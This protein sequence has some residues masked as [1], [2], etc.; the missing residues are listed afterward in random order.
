MA[1]PSQEI[2]V[3]GSGKI[4]RGFIADL[5]K[6]SGFKL[7]FCDTS[8]PLIEAMR[9]AGKYT[10]VNIGVS[11][12]E[13]VEISN[14]E[15]L[16]IQNDQPAYLDKMIQ[17]DFIALAVYSG[18]FPAIAKDFCEVIR[19]RMILRPDNDFNIILCVNVLGTPQFFADYFASHLNEQEMDFVNSHVGLVQALVLRAG[20]EATEEL[21]AKDP[22]V[23]V[24]NGFGSLYL[25]RDAF[26]GEC[27]IKSVELVD[28]IADRFTRKIYS[29]NLGH[30]ALAYMG[31]LC[32]MTYINE[33]LDNQ[34]IFHTMIGA[35]NEAEIGMQKEFGFSDEDTKKWRQEIFTI[36]TNPNTKDEI[37]RVAADPLRKLSPMDRLVGP[38]KIVERQ[39]GFPYY[40]AR[41]IACALKYDYTADQNA[42]KLQQM[43]K[44][45]GLAESL[46]RIC[47]VDENSI[48]GKLILAHYNDVFIV[49]G[50]EKC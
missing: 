46:C 18:A 9:K 25:D 42:Q 13:T 28:Q 5:A 43:I 20:I 41:V 38:A 24:T 1:L 12:T 11:Q 49:K 34:Q 10:V 32:Q 37:T 30:C 45:C 19:Q 8:A 26:K 23:V 35:Y 14:Y 3:V 21:K 50:N 47:A 15:A 22:L 16:H 44:E 4:G 27:R 33:T 36:L 29:G 7:V 2:V 31:Y 17:N 6:K 39:G 48:L 40:L